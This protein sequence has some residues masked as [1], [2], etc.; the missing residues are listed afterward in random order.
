MEFITRKSLV[1]AKLAH[2]IDVAAE[3]QQW[4]GAQAY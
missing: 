1:E 3:N 4:V 2:I